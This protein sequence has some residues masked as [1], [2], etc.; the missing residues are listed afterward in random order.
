[1]SWHRMLQRY[2]LKVEESGEYDPFNILQAGLAN[3]DVP[4]ASVSYTVG[5]SREY[6]EVKCSCT[7]TVQC[8]QAETWINMAG[9]SA[10][11]KALELV[12][13]GATQLEIPTLPEF[14]EP[15]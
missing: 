12:N 9:E 15:T 4:R 10:Y 1:M 11:R 3:K 7:V 5:T 2:G 6:G 8:P 14:E 13:A